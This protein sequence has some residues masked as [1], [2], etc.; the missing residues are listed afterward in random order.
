M[1]DAA[2]VIGVGPGLG[3]ALV[4]KFAAE[5]LT[6]VAAARHASSLPGFEDDTAAGRVV[7]RDCDATVPAQIEEL[8][9]SMH[10]EPA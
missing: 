6:V 3:S 1:S 4:R 2:V 7:L 10:L 9:S 5:G 8:F